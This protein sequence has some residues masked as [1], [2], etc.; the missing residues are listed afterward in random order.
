MEQG[1]KRNKYSLILDNHLLL[2][3]SLYMSI[4]FIY[5]MEIH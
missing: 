1:K 4:C 3:I 2:F 5:L